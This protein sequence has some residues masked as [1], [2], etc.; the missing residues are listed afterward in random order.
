MR[1]LLPS[2]NTALHI[3]SILNGFNQQLYEY[4]ANVLFTFRK[5]L[6][7][8]HV[9]TKLIKESK[10]ALD[11]HMYVGFLLFDLSKGF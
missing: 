9:L 8:Q 11:K 3:Q 7:Y 6:E 1:N 5:K 2:K 4:F 10:R